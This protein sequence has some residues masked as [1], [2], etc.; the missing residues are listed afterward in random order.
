[1]SF[2]NC[3]RLC[4]EDLSCDDKVPGVS[5]SSVN[6]QLLRT[7]IEE[8]FSVLITDNETVTKICSNCYED[9]QY[10]H[11]VRKRVQDTDNAI[12]QYYSQLNIKHDIEYLDLNDDETNRSEIS[13]HDKEIREIYTENDIQDPSNTNCGF[14]TTKKNSQEM[15]DDKSLKTEIINCGINGE[16]SLRNTT[17]KRQ[18]KS[19][20]KVKSTSFICYICTTHFDT[21]GDLDEHLPSH[22]GSVSSI[23][24]FCQLELTTVRHLNMHLRIT[25]YRKGKRIPCEECKQNGLAREFSSTYKLEDHV[26]RVH[27]GIKDIPELKFV[28]T[29]CGKKFSRSFHLKLHENTHTKSI[30]FQCKFC[31]FKTT[32]RSGLLRH[33]R[34]H[35]SE[36]PFKCD[37]CDARFTQSNAL[38]LHKNGRH[39]KER[40]FVCELC[41]GNVRFKTKYSLQSHMR[42]HEKSGRVQRGPKAGPIEKPTAEPHLKCEFCPAVYYKERFLCRHILEKHPTENIP[43]IACELCLEVNKK[44]YFITQAEK[45]LHLIYHTK[46]SKGLRRERSCIDCGAVYQTS[47]AMAKHRQSHVKHECMECGKTYKGRAGLRLHYLSVHYESRPYKCNQCDAAY[48][49][50]TQLSSHMKSHR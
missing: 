27:Q 16:P 18:T 2:I 20:T 10:V 15:I 26:R 32:S 12:K 37:L 45:E 29:Y 39:S 28:C 25:H 19:K 9:V 41:D 48:S 40:P 7:L 33:E 4:L 31:K 14:F 24:S 23:C 8:C 46:M 6:D 21:L 47:D 34:I 36:K 1:M 42:I 11:K 22:V 35:T 30:M 49:Q 13:L 17:T 50:F 43:M 3:C 5:E 38:Q 44:V